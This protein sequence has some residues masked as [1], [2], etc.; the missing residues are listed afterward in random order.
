[1]SEELSV[2]TDDPHAWAC[3]RWPGHPVAIVFVDSAGSRVVP[4]TVVRVNKTTITVARTGREGYTNRFPLDGLKL[5]EGTGFSRR[6]QWLLPV[7]HPEV[8]QLLGK[9]GRRRK[10]RTAVRALA[11]A[12]GYDDP[13]DAREELGAAYR[14]LH[15]L[16]D[17]AR[18]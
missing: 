7:G 5:R 10:L 16:L 1:V 18:R 9:Q 6:M 3:S 12:S 17:E 14:L 11:D 2:F 8:Q 13:A 4:G 15:E